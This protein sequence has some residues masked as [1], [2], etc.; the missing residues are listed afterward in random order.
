M[1]SIIWFSMLV[2]C[3]LLSVLSMIVGRRECLFSLCGV[4]KMTTGPI[5]VAQFSTEQVKCQIAA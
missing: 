5:F 1:S 2:I 3:D 4:A